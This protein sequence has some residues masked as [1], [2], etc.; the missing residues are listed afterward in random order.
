[1]NFLLDTCAVSELAKPRPNPG[2]IAWMDGHD[3][4]SL[5]L[6]VVTLGEIQK[7]ISQL[8]NRDRQ[9]SLRE[10]LQDA[11]VDRFSSRLLMLDADIMLHWGHVLGEQAR[12]GIAL[13]VVDMLIASTA[14]VHRMTVVT[15]N[16]SD[17]ERC[18][19]PVANPWR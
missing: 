14:H 18:G 17:M 1:M 5:Y 10:W 13:P 9:G 16:V 12:Q 19:A 2:V 11:V 3:E 6:S 15:R 4:S 8:G 7:G